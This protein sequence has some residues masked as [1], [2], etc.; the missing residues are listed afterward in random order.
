MKVGVI[1]TTAKI[2]F[3]FVLAQ[4]L[5]A[6]S[7]EVKVFSG[8][9]FRS[10]VTEL[11]PM[12]ERT[13]GH[14]VVATFD[15]NDGF[16]RRIKAGESFDVLLIGTPTFDVLGD[17]IAPAPRV[18]V[19]RAGLGVAVRAGTPRPDIT[20]A[21]A[22]KRALLGVNSVSYVGDGLSGVLFRALLDRLGIAE[23]MKPKLKPTENANVVKA[24]AS[25][26]ADLAVHV[27]PGILAERGVE[28]VGP[29]PAEIQSY[30]DLTAGLNAAAKEPEAAKGFIT[31][32][33]SDA[34]I[35]VIKAKGW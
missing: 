10:V 11:V 2:A 30:I 21:D 16:E 18:V 12:F 3:F 13:T 8:G 7:A 28:L 1:A 6:Q 14:K 9:G 34:A 25:G 26:E 32:L 33:T 22:L 23:S 20:S 24:V 29:V 19:G 4:S 31:F 35:P 15:S 5:A 27:M 17:K